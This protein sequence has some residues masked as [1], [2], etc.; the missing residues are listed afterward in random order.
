MNPYP[1]LIVSPEEIPN[2]S[3]SMSYPD[4]EVIFDAPNLTWINKTQA[5]Y[6]W[7]FGDGNV[8]SGSE[9]IHQYSKT[10]KYS[11]ILK[12]SCDN[13]IIQFQDNIE[14]IEKKEIPT[15]HL[16]SEEQAIRKGLLI[17]VFILLTGSGIL[18]II[19]NQKMR[20]T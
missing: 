10:G 5:N 9:V 6:T 17:F 2:S 16:A 14:I 11:V 7:S 18:S 1:N 15:T 13:Q 4:T 3:I 20:I 19:Y 12:I 8:T